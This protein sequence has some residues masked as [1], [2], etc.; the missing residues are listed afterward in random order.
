MTFFLI[1]P[2]VASVSAWTCFPVS[3][4]ISSLEGRGLGFSTGSE[5]PH[6]IR[7]VD[8]ISRPTRIASIFF[9]VFSSSGVGGVSDDPHKERRACLVGDNEEEGAVKIDHQMI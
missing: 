3:G 6:P 5:T 1:F 9:I 7:D 4:R 2:G 8:K